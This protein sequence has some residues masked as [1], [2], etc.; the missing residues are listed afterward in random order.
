MKKTLYF[1]L[2]TTFFFSIVLRVHAQC[3]IAE[4]VA[5]CTPSNMQFLVNS[6][7]IYTW[8]FGDGTTP[9]LGTETITYNYSSTGSYIVTAIGSGCN[10]LTVNIPTPPTSFFTISEPNPLCGQDTVTFTV[11]NPMSDVLYEWDFGDGSPTVNGPIVPHAFPSTAAMESYT[12]TL[13]EADVL[14][15]QIETVIVLDSPDATLLS[16]DDFQLCLGTDTITFT[17]SNGSSTSAQNTSETINWGDGTSNSLTPGWVDITHTYTEQGFFYITYTV[18]GPFSCPLSTLTYPFFNGSDGTP[19]IGINAGG[20]QGGV[21]VSDIL[22]GS[23]SGVEGNP[24]G[25]IYQVTSNTGL[26]ATFSHP[27]PDSFN[28]QFFIPS[29][30]SIAPVGGSNLQN[31]FYIAVSSINPCKTA[32]AGAGPITVSGGAEAGIAVTPSGGACVGEP[33][34]FASTSTSLVVTEAECIDVLIPPTDISWSIDPPIPGWSGDMDDPLIFNAAGDYTVTVVAEAC[35]ESAT[36]SVVIPITAPPTANLTTS[37]TLLCPGDTLII[38][39]ISSFNTTGYEWEITPAG[40]DFNPPSNENSEDLD[41]TFNAPG[42][43]VV[44]MTATNSCTEDTD[45]IF[46]EVVGLQVT[47]PADTIICEDTPSF[48]V[49]IGTPSGGI[50]SV[51]DGTIDPDTGLFDPNSVLPGTTTVTVSYTY[52]DSQG[53]QCI[54]SD[55]MMISIDAIPTAVISGPDLLFYCVNSTPQPLPNATPPGGVWTGQSGGMVTNIPINVVGDSIYI[56]TVTTL[57]GCVH[58]DTISVI[59]EEAIQAV[60]MQDDIICVGESVQLTGTPSGGSWLSNNVDVNEV[61]TSNIPDEYDLIYQFG[62]GT[63]ATFDTIMITVV[64]VSFA[65]VDDVCALATTDLNTYLTLLPVLMPALDPANGEWSDANGIVIPD[66]MFVAPDVTTNTTF[67]LTYTYDPNG[68]ACSNTVDIDVIVNPVA[69]FDVEGIPCVGADIDVLNYST[70]AQNYIWEMGDGTTYNNN[71]SDHEYLASGAYEITLTAADGT[72]LCS[73]SSTY[74]IFIND[75]PVADF[76]ADPLS[77]CAPVT[78]SLMN[79]SEGTNLTYEWDYDNGTMDNTD[80]P[81]NETFDAVLND[82]TYNIILTLSNVCGTDS[83]VETIDVEALP[84]AIFSYNGPL[85]GD[86][87]STFNFEG[88]GNPTTYNWTIDNVSVSTDEDLMY[89]FQGAPNTVTYEVALTVTNA[90]STSTYNETITISPSVVNAD[91]T[92]APQTGCESESFQFTSFAPPDATF[93]W[94]FGDSNISSD[95]NP[96]N[97]Y[98]SSGTYDVSLTVTYECGSNTITQSITVNPLPQVDFIPILTGCVDTQVQFNNDAPLGNFSSFIWDFGDGS[99]PSPDTDP[100]HN[101]TTAGTYTVTLTGIDMNGCENSAAYDIE[102]LELPDITFS[103]TDNFEC[104]DVDVSFT[105]TSASN[106]VNYQWDFGDGNFSQLPNPSHPYNNAD[107]YVASLT[108][109]DDN[110]CVNTFSDDVFIIA[111]PVA[112]FTFPNQVYCVPAT[113]TFTN[114]SIDNNDNQWDFGD[115]FTSTNTNPTHTY[116]VP[117]IYTVTLSVINGDCADLITQLITIN[118]TPSVMAS[119]DNLLCSGDTD[120]SLS[121]TVSGGTAPYIYDWDNAPDVENPTGLPLGI[122]NLTVTDDNGCTATATATITEPAAM[123]T[124]AVGEAL[125]CNGDTNGNI[126][127]TING[128]TLPYNYLWSNGMTSQNPSGLPAGT[129]TVTVT[130]FNGCTLTDGANITEPLLPLVLMIDSVDIVCFG[131]MNGTIELSVTGGTTP[132]T[133][134]WS[135]GQTTEDIS[136]LDAG[137]YLVSVTDANGCS[138]TISTIINQPPPLS[139]PVIIANEPLCNG[140]FNG[141]I[142]LGITGGTPPYF[143]NWDNLPDVEDPMNIGAGIY[144]VTITDANGCPEFGSITVNEPDEL[145]IS[146]LESTGVTCHDG[147]DG[148][149]SL[150]VSGGTLGYTIEWSNGDTGASLS[151]LSAGTYF[152]TITDNNNCDLWGSIQ[153]EQPD[154]PIDYDVNVTPVSCNGGNDGFAEI[155]NVSGGVSPYTYAWSTGGFGTSISGGA[156]NYAYVITDANDCEVS[157]AVEILEP[158]PII[159]TATSIHPTCWNDDDG[160]IIITDISGGT[161]PYQMGWN[162]NDLPNE[163]YPLNGSYPLYEPLPD[164]TY[165]LFGLDAAGCPFTFLDTI[166]NPPQVTISLPEQEVILPGDSVL[167][168]PI[169][170]LSG[171]EYQWFPPYGLSDDTIDNP[172]ASPDVTTTYTLTVMDDNGCSASDQITIKVDLE[173]DIY[174]P[175]AFSPNYDG[176]N[177][178]FMI[179]GNLWVENIKTFRI[180]DR[181]GELLWE[182]KDF[183]SDDPNFG[184]NGRLRGKPLNPGVYVYYAEIKFRGI[185]ELFLKKGNVTL[186]K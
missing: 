86:E 13:T 135:N 44:V 179:Y 41:V 186:V 63:C 96:S 163:F 2:A 155:I 80:T 108:V 124:N 122:Y 72:N 141:N 148:T 105:S 23:I 125:L 111:N 152:V 168:N 9:Q 144:N 69:D 59:V 45:T 98:Q 93:A 33:I 7:G 147:A 47:A 158:D 76:V 100:T 119:D 150:V 32:I 132:Y 174:I 4:P 173:P 109:T 43:Y 167:L 169:V 139:T 149:A 6:S 153:V 58:A 123:A 24:A 54:S 30:D 5:N 57:G 50:W 146:S 182:A 128:G 55:D 67:T 34:S 14:C 31:S 64:G 112:D 115:S 90:C 48:I 178:V 176:T 134:E 35:G 66:G 99:I 164:S 19:N 89:S 180:F 53:A 18:E 157:G 138:G 8:D 183:P 120:G 12:V 171:L 172:Y 92:I 102:I 85:C 145:L 106:I 22:T 185:D 68:L 107:N 37:D 26:I 97:T 127:L 28:Y 175:N 52:S 170:S 113:I 118:E 91:F 142:D 74:P 94:D 133:Y 75:P 3:L 82:E 42:N 181:W 104:E 1:S 154:F 46:V 117:G 87:I 129:Y 143:F 27:P 36:T 131:N 156:G 101:Y 16:E 177:D 151:G 15:P 25:T 73:N 165:I 161:A 130:D 56:Y 95:Q 88:Y 110:G 184:W 10:P 49:G 62:T 137:L 78:V 83:D 166:S 81:P 70:D 159:T 136:G 21:C 60:A 160:M 162:P 114:N 126:S 116:N 20:T 51:D 61:F 17:I 84:V 77:G 11:N 40:W 38:D 121:A 103:F 65:P 39:N 140:D 79:N 29:C 71:F